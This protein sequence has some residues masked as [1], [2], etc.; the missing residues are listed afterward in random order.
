[1]TAVSSFMLAASIA[2]MATSAYGQ[3]KTS[4]AQKEMTA[5]SQREETARRQQ[6]QLEAQRAQRK[7]FRDAQAANAVGLANIT[8]AGASAEGGSALPGLYGQTSGAMNQ[9]SVDLG[10]NLKTGMDIFDAKA[11]YT[12]AAS[13][14]ATGQGI[15]QLGKDIFASSAAIGRVG[16]TMFG[17]PNADKGIY[18]WA[19]NTTVVKA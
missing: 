12:R 9:Q 7:I 17:G 14:A 1:M 3:K 5:A 13:S 11:D 15:S 8:N 6:A 16:N 10:Q 18:N 4:D 19:A 2:G